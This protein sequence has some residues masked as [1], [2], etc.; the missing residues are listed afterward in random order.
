MKGHEALGRPKVAGRIMTR[1][2]RVVMA[3]AVVAALPA[4]LRAN[5]TPIGDAAPAAAPTA[6]SQGDAK[7]GQLIFERNCGLCHGMS[8]AGGRGP[9]LRT[10]TLQNASNLAEITAVIKGG[11]PPAMPPFWLMPDKDLA[12]VA[13]FVQ[14]L[15]QSASVEKLPGD[16]A[17]GKL[18]YEESGCSG[19]HIMAGEGSGYGPELTHIGGARSIG[20]LRK[21][22]I[23]P[24]VSILPD[25]QYVELETAS[26]EI[27]QGVRRNEDTLTIQLQDQ[28]GAFHS[29][30][31]PTLKSLKRLKGE[32]PMPSFAEALS[33]R[34]MD[35][36]VSYLSTRRRR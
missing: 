30:H 24:K 5:P 32:T 16:P 27:I 31:K 19:C 18:V 21:T 3:G 29:L 12:D 22:L 28:S 11:L 20:Q 25:F 4:L 10:A 15:G 35:D 9:N 7:A 23:D 33:P 6:V 1:L 26:G 17:A 2:S 14:T 36:I 13:L 8:G 34:Q